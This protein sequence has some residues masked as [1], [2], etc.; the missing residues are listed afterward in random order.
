MI[1][2]LGY[3]A[4]VLGVLVMVFWAFRPSESPQENSSMI[5]KLQ[6]P[7]ALAESTNFPVDYA[8]IA[9]YI[10][11][12][13][14][15]FPNIHIAATEIATDVKNTDGASYV[16]IET[17]SGGSSWPVFD[18]YADTSGWLVVF[19]PKSTVDSRATN[20]SV[21]YMLARKNWYGV[22]YPQ[23][24]HWFWTRTSSEKYATVGYE[25]LAVME[26]FAGEVGRY[27]PNDDLRKT[28]FYHFGFQS[29]ASVH[30]AVEHTDSMSFF[31]PDGVAVE[32]VSVAF[33]IDGDQQD[34]SLSIDGK[35]VFRNVDPGP[36]YFKNVPL[37][38]GRHEVDVSHNVMVAITVRE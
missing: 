38:P 5:M 1:R 16:W 28:K 6:P 34:N 19:L 15:D 9:R 12:P 31:I 13:T 2:R 30:V 23:R 18:L 3:C 37:D 22:T 29:A 33:W 14:T 26:R 20:S 7:K 32:E 17:T 35:D 24:H 10:K 27:W 11:Y 8:G 4:M 25:S 36:I 21:A